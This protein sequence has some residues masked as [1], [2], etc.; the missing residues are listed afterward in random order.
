MPA[1]D[2]ALNSL[3]TGEQPGVELITTL[4]SADAEQMP[5]LFAAANGVRRLGVGEAVHLRAIVEFSNYCRKNCLYCGLRRDNKSLP[6]YRLTEQEIIEAVDNAAAMG[7]RT[8]VL[9]S[10]EDLYYTAANIAR[11]IDRIKNK[12]DL[13]VTLSVGERGYADYK[14]WREAGADRYLLKQETVDEKLFQYLKPDSRLRERLQCL[15]WLKELGYQT[16]SGNMVGL[17]GQNPTTL[18]GDILFMRELEVEMAGIGPFL[19]HHDTP[20]KDAAPGGLEL[21]LKTLAVARLCLPRAHLPATTA[22]STLTP[23]GR[24]LALKSGAN[25]IMPNLT[26]L[27]VRDKY[28]IYP[29]KS[30]IIEHPDR[31]LK[32]IN[33]LLAEL[34]RPLAKDH[35]HACQITGR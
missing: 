9:Q 14:T 17:P 18:A 8:V 21:T 23:G 10:G 22:L 33:K 25:V 5:A 3:L 13:A 27:H 32:N 31:T 20:L 28:L 2:A 6:R 26:P 1:L 29:Q 7:F 12:Y 35:G 19:P 11:L 24:E 16:G 4:L 34:A 30:D 15:H